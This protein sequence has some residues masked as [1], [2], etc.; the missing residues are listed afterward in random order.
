MARE[1]GNHYDLVHSHYWLSGWVGRA[2]KEYLDVPLV[3]SFHTLGKVKNYSLAYGEV[4]SRPS[5][6]VAR[7][8]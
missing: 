5:G 6:S 8:A 3:A 4:P 2:A 7:R 1:E